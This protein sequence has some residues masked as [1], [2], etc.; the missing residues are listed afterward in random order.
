[1]KI[2]SDSVQV[3]IGPI[4]DSFCGTSVGIQIL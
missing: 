3:D 2:N 4:W 1:M